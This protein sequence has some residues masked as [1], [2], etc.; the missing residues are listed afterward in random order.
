MVTIRHNTLTSESGSSPPIGATQ[1]DE[2]HEVVGLYNRRPVYGVVG[3]AG[4]LTTFGVAGNTPTV[5]AT[6][7]ASSFHGTGASSQTRYASAATTNATA[8][9]SFAAP[10]YIP[11]LNAYRSAGLAFNAY[12]DFFD[13]SY[14]S[15]ATGARMVFGLT[16]VVGNILDTDD[17]TPGNNNGQGIWFSYSTNRGGNWRIVI[18]K[19][20]TTTQLID[21]G[22]AFAPGVWSFELI[23]N[24]TTASFDW[25][26]R[27]IGGTGATGSYTETGGNFPSNRATNYVCAA[28]LTTL[29]TTARNFGV[30]S[31]NVDR[32]EPA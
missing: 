28:G 25:S 3:G 22:V 12:L 11:P 4:S 24:E 18:R 21:T 8:S 32:L 30:L 5:S 19:D 16:R 20:S 7:T 14:G 13:A 27:Q 26:I 15:G 17:G 31:I 10:M 9:V 23:F 6:G 2:A 29:T 1:W